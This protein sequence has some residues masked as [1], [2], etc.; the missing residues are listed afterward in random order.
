MELD[1]LNLENY[2]FELSW[3]QQ[4]TMHLNDLGV[5]RTVMNYMTH[6]DSK[7]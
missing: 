3:S 5:N 2:A 4:K 7:G 1:L 6:L